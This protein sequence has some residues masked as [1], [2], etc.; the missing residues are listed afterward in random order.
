MIHAIR[1]AL[2][3]VIN[4]SCLSEQSFALFVHCVSVEHSFRL[5][6]PPPLHSTPPHLSEFLCH[7]ATPATPSR[8][9]IPPTPAYLTRTNSGLGHAGARKYSY[10][11]STSRFFFSLFL[12]P[13]TITASPAPALRFLKLFLTAQEPP[14]IKNQDQRSTCWLFVGHSAT[15]KSTT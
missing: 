5:Q 15:H 3:K 13:A 10:P 8:A 11:P 12:L 14:C 6:M 7:R 2:C 4:Y 9:R 1:T